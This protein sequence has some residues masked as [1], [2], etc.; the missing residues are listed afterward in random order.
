MDESSVAHDLPELYRSVLDRIASL[1]AAG[2]RREGQLIRQAAIRVYS[3]AWDT[4]TMKALDAL[5][6][7]ADRVLD[8][9][10]R[11]RHPRPVHPAVRF[12]RLR[13]VAV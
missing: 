12:L 5:R 9:H 1:E 7:R 2:H 3:A 10:E 13:R 4:R 6:T 8:G 11:P